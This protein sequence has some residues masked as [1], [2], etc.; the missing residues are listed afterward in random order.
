GITV[1]ASSV[2]STTQI[3]ANITITAAAATGPGTATVTN[4]GPGGGTSG[5]QKITITKPAPTL[6]SLVPDTASRLATLD[7]VF[8]GTNFLP[9]VSSVNFSDPGITLNASSVDSATQ[10]TANI[11]IT[12]LAATGASTVTVTNAGPGGGTSAP[13]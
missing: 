4:A 13:Q 6:T 11:T 2:D 8:T 9:G 1:N 10:I 7:V 3:T 5:P 12:A